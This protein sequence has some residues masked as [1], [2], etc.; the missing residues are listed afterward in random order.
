MFRDILPSPTL[1]INEKAVAMKKQGIDVFHLGFGQSPFGPAQSMVDAIRQNASRKS[2]SD[3]EG[4]WPLREQIASF[5]SVM[6]DR[7]VSPEQ[8]LVAPGS[9]SLLYCLLASYSRATVLL[10]APSWVSYAPQAKLAGH[11]VLI[12]PTDHQSRYR[13][14]ADLLEHY[15]VKARQQ[16]PNVVLVLNSPGNPDGLVY[17]KEA[18]TRLS[19][20]LG[21]HQVD[22]ISDEIYSLLQFEGTRS[23]IADIHINTFVTTGLSKWAGVG[24][25][26]LGVA[27]LPANLKEQHK[28]AIKGVASETYSCAPTPVQWAAMAAYSGNHHM[29][30]RVRD[31]NAI[32]KNISTILHGALENHQILVHKPQ[33]GFYMMLDFSPY[34]SALTRRGITNDQQ[35]C[36]AL[37]ESAHVAL[38][39]GSSFGMAPG[40]LTARLAFV[41]FDGDAALREL[42]AEGLSAIHRH[43]SRMCCAVE[44][45]GLFLRG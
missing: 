31:Q 9:K 13:I 2:Y 38:L 22:V 25:W 4:L 7:H 3:V 27:I 30:N 36:S 17:S 35:L 26:R 33:G 19:E 39:P 28:R 29:R 16:S 32:L 11:K 1:V 8:V 5:H 45:I 37:L 41:D 18:L 21:R 40:M 14:S 44:R 15:V 43:S 20:V 12:I 23:S 42:A 10:P 34:K 6:D 24:G